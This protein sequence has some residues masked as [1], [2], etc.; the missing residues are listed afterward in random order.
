VVIEAQVTSEAIDERPL[1]HDRLDSVVE[2][3]SPRRE[4]LR[5]RES[6]RR[7]WSET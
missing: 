2:K 6:S 3:A 5:A 4:T 1:R 7:D